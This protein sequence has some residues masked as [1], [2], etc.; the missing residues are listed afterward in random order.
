[1]CCLHEIHLLFKD[2]HRLK[3]KRWKIYAMQVEIKKRV[4]LLTLISDKRD[5]KPKMVTRNK[6]GHYT[7]I[8]GST[9]QEVIKCLK[10]FIK[11][12]ST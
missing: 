9:H 7:M 8:K 1:M 11:H 3:V 5:F 10:I 6:E 4:G 12:Q 2:M